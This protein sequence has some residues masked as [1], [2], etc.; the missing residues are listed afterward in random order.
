M[1]LPE[2]I[3]YQTEVI[4]PRMQVLTQQ[5]HMR[6][7]M[8][9]QIYGSSNLEYNWFYQDLYKDICQHEDVWLGQNF[10][11][12]AT[13]PMHCEPTTAILRM[14]CTTLLCQ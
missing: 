6:F 2:G 9:A 10:N 11:V 13:S 8:F 12:D 14:L 7:Q 3:K 4:V 5:A 1:F